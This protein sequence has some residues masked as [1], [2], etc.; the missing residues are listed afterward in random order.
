L[1]VIGIPTYGTTKE[2][3]R[4]PR[5]FAL[6]KDYASKEKYYGRIWNVVLQEG[7]NHIY[8][9]NFIPV[10]MMSTLHDMVEDEVKWREAIK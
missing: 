1:R 7:V 4:I 8:F 6:L 2:G 9:I 3:F 10:L 5:E